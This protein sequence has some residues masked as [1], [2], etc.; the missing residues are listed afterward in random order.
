MRYYFKSLDDGFIGDL[1]EL[2]P[3]GKKLIKKDF[4]IVT[5]TKKDIIAGII[6]Q[7]IAEGE[8]LDNICGIGDPFPGKFEF[9]FWVDN[10]PSIKEWLGR[11]KRLRYESIVETLFSIIK[12]SKEID[13]DTAGALI[14]ALKKVTTELRKDEDDSAKTLIQ[15]HV[16][17]GGIL[18][19]HHEDS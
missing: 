18:K 1:Y 3:E 9:Y 12:K 7:K 5:D 4:E 19:G 8:S 17:S 13:K 15:T 6:C 11:A 2:R 14:E 16:W 10:D